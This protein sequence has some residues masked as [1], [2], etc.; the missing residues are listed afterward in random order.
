LAR[1]IRIPGE[2]PQ[3][4]GV[5]R[6]ITARKEAERALREREQE[7]RHAQRLEAVGKLAGGIAHDFNNL[8]TVINGQARFALE[9]TGGDCEVR[10]ELEEIERAGAQAASLTQQLLAYSRRQMLHPRV[11][12][13]NAVI[14]ET[15]AMLR[16]LIG[17]HIRIETRFADEEV[18]IRADRGQFE[19]VLVNLVVN[20]RDA[21]PEGGIITLETELLDLGADDDRVTRWEVTPGEFVGIRVT[22][23]GKGM[24]PATLEHAFEPFFTTKEQGK[25]TGLG[26]ATVF[27]IVKQSDGH[28]LATSEPDAGTTVH[29]VLPRCSDDVALVATPAEDRPAR[30]LEGTVLVVE[31]EDAVRKLTVKALE[32]EGCTV[33]AAPNGLEALAV[34]D[35]HD[36]GIDLVVT[37]LVMPDMGGRELAEEL[38]RR[39]PDLP[40]LFMSG[41]DDAMV[42]DVDPASDFLA[43][44]FT[45]AQL[46]AR[47]AAVIGR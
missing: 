6:D 21:M 28:V 11:L 15:E 9:N 14:R 40:V 13:P 7:L 3:L 4:F 38:R 45:P 39:R 8:L 34:V 31:D 12:D 42:G 18:R 47:V 37:D 30:S 10:S 46:T 5:Y 26:L 29:V 22:D 23:T 16:R 20:A 32:R 24:D 17:E 25:G 1:E 36:G 35:R 19:Q 41:Y 2:P 43:K 33:L 27:G 44:P